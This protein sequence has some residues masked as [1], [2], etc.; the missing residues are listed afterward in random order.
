MILLAAATPAPTHLDPIQLV[1]HADIVV[2][3]VIAGLV[4]ASIWVWTIIVSFAL[5]MG[6]VRRQSTLKLRVSRMMLRGPPLS[7]TDC[8]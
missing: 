6:S 8:R 7:W 1:L 5:R 4:L 3:V 2:Q